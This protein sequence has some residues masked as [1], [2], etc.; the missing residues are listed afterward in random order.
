[1]QSRLQ[2]QVPG[3]QPARP[4]LVHEGLGAN[5]AE[6]CTREPGVFRAAMVTWDARVGKDDA[7][8]KERK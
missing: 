8:S 1:M 4:G 5:A 7:G 6:C 2:V 3:N